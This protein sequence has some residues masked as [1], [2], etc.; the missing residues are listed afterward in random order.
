MSGE[1]FDWDGLFVSVDPDIIARERNKARLLKQSTWWKNRLGEGMCHYCGQ[2]FPPASLTMDHI[3]PI[4]RG[5]R[6]EKSNCVPACQECNRQKHN[7]PTLSW[8]RLLEEKQ[9]DK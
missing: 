9:R 8:K 6:T 2:R 5:G 3:T 1:P 7:L 4:A